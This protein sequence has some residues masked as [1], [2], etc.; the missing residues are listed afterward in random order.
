[1]PLYENDKN[2]ENRIKVKKE[3]S[4]AVVFDTENVTASMCSIISDR[5]KIKKLDRDD[6][7]DGIDSK[8][9]RR[10]FMDTDIM[11]RRLAAMAVLRLRSE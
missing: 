10:C 3:W 9:H 7:D 1:M 4:E 5:C 6:F 8:A 2:A 11:A